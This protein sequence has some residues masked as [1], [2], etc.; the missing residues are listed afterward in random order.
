MEA[1]LARWGNSLAVRIPK[2]I[3]AKASLHSGDRVEMTAEA[4]C[5]ILKL[6]V[7]RYELSDLLAGMSVE[8]MHE[9]FDWGDDVGREAVP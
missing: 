4:G 8:A 1:Q 6:A 3:A 9:A 2:D 7:P 5:V